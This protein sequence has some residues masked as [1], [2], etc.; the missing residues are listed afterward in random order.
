MILAS[1]VTGGEGC[2]SG[3]FGEESYEDK[4]VVDIGYGG[5]TIYYSY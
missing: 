5:G 1:A 2:A 3:C 4:E